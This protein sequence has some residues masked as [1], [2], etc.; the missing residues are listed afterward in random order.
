MTKTCNTDWKAAGRANGARLTDQPLRFELGKARFHAIHSFN[1]LRPVDKLANTI[2]QRHFRIESEDRTRVGRAANAMPDISRLEATN[3]LRC[4][5]GSEHGS[6]ARATSAMED[7]RP[8]QTFS[9]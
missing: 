2:D 7:A 9:A 4:N 5:P 8:V 1:V 6:R 3:A